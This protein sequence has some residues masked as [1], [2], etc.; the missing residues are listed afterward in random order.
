MKTLSRTLATLCLA[1]AAV[2]ARAEVLR[3]AVTANFT[4][5]PLAAGPGTLTLGFDLAEPIPGVIAEGDTSFRVEDIDIDA[6]FNGIATNSTVNLA[7]WFAEP[8]YGYFGLDVRLSNMLVPGDRLQMILVTPSALFSG[9]ASA[10]TLDRLNLSDLAGG[11]Y[12]YPTGYGA[13][14]ADGLL[15]GATYDVSAVPEPATY[16]LMLVGLA[17]VGGLARSRR[18]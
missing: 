6:S 13:H 10:P 3:V 5:P 14:T 1:A 18:A 7:G 12:Y 11:I 9:T 2:A 8:A 16:A 17:V 4:L 15:S